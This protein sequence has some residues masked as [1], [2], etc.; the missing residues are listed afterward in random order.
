[1]HIAITQKDRVILDA[2]FL[3]HRIRVPKGG[4]NFFDRPKVSNHLLASESS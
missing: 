2:V 1:M 4:F 3:F